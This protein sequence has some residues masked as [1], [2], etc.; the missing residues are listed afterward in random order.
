MTAVYP[1]EQ[2]EVQTAVLHPINAGAAVIFQEE[3][4]TVNVNVEQS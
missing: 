4:R 2:G 1:E 3:D